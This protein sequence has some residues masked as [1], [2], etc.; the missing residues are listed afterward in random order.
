MIMNIVKKIIL[1]I[2][3]LTP[4]CGNMQAAV[5][6]KTV[7]A[8]MRNPSLCKSMLKAT[9]LFGTLAVCSLNRIRIFDKK[10]GLKRNR[11]SDNAYEEDSRLSTGDRL[12]W[13]SFIGLPTCTLFAGLSFVGFLIAQSQRR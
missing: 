2:L 10:G 3:V 7:V 6:S 12:D 1:S 8:S 13:L 5:A 9:I 11:S 4:L